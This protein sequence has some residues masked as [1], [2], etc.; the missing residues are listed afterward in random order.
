M[1]LKA[2]ALNC[3]LKPTPAES[4]CG[5][6]LRHLSTALK[7]HDVETETVR[8]ADFNVLPGVSHDEGNGDEWPQIKSRIDAAEILVMGTPVWMGSPSSICKRVAE[9]LDA[10]LSDTD[11]NNRIPTFAKVA[12][13]GVVGNEDGAHH[14][15]AECYQWLNDVG[16]TI[17]A[18]GVAYCVGEAMQGKDFKDLPNVPD[19]VQG[20]I[21][22]AASNAAH[23]ARLLK[24]QPYSGT[25]S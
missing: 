10:V 5:L 24:A 13:V 25:P 1:S 22:M 9:R 12:I 8:V 2:I 21:D 19:K 3:T 16:F 4:S 18:S 6:M 7:K 20:T 15:S 14:V 17:P 23:L 11:D